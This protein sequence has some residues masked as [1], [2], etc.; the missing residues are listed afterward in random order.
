[1]HLRA[2]DRSSAPVRFV[3]AAHTLGERDTL[4]NKFMILDLFLCFHCRA[5]IR[6]SVRSRSTSPFVFVFIIAS[7][8]GK[9]TCPRFSLPL[10]LFSF[11]FF[12]AA[13]YIVLIIARSVHNS[14]LQSIRAECRECLC[15]IFIPNSVRT[16]LF[17]L[18][19]FYC[20]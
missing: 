2:S 1:M 17:F 10:S 13:A 8:I 12:K 7:K 14:V 6:C 3:Y 4:A 19:L 15:F 5:I 11:F 16:F 18:F 20:R 9:I